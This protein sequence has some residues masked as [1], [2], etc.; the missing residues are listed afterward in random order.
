MLADDLFAILST[1]PR[2]TPDQQAELLAFC[3]EREIPLSNF[4]HVPAG[5]KGSLCRIDLVV[6]QAYVREPG[7]QVTEIYPPAKG[8]DP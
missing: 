5:G 1:A 7:G 8:V 2:P 4:A 3:R 6:I